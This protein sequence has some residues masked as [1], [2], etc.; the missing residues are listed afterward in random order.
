MKQK[1]HIHPHYNDECDASIRKCNANIPVSLAAAIAS[2]K[3][4][5]ICP[6]VLHPFSCF[7]TPY[8]DASY[9]SIKEDIRMQLMASNGIGLDKAMNSYREIYKIP[10]STHKLRYQLNK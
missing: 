8:H 1:D 5:V 2:K 7:S 4:Q 9:I 10:F 6:Q 3:L